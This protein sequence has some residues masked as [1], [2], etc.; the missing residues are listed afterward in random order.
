MVCMRAQDCVSGGKDGNAYNSIRSYSEILLRSSVYA[1]H[2]LLSEHLQQVVTHADKPVWKTSATL[3][4]ILLTSKLFPRIV[5]KLGGEP[6]S[7]DILLLCC[8]NIII[9]YC[10]SV[11]S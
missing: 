11:Y 2:K 7:S 9:V 4:A 10:D 1:E 3:H 6:R 8:Y 5:A